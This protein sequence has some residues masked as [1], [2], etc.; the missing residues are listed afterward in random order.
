MTKDVAN[1]LR[2]Y[3]MNYAGSHERSELKI[4]E[5]NGSDQYNTVT[6][7]SKGSR[8]ETTC[9]MYEIDAFMTIAKACGINLSIGTQPDTGFLEYY[10]C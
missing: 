10:F 3:L 8:D 9:F 5:Y 4:E 6:I 1:L 7:T 2:I